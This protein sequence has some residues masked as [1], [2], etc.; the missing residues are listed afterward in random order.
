M[1]LHR[2]INLPFSLTLPDR[3][4]FIVF[5]LAPRHSD[6][7][8]GVFSFQSNGQWHDGNPLRVQM[9]CYFMQFRFVQEQFAVTERVVISVAV[10][11]VARNMRSF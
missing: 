1:P 4:P 11:W 8:F 9:V 2:S 10:E 5:F 6:L 7:Y 3:F